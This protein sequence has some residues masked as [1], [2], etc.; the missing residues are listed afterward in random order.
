VRQF[1]LHLVEQA[2]LLGVV[3]GLIQIG[4]IRDHEPLS[5][6]GLRIERIAVQ[7]AKAERTVGIEQQSVHCGA[8]HRGVSMVLPKRLPDVGLEIEYALLRS[9]SI[10]TEIT[11]S[12]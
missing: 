7:V 6:P 3:G 2:P 10:S 11:S 1:P 9:P 8:D 5:L 12:A 4:R